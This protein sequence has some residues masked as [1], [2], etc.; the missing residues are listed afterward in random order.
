MS[1]DSEDEIGAQEPVLGEKHEYA[2]PR[3][4]PEDANIIPPMIKEH[5]AC[6]ASLPNEP[7]SEGDVYMVKAEQLPEK[8]EPFVPDIILDDNC[9]HCGH[10][11]QSPSEPNPQ[12]RRNARK[13][14]SSAYSSGSDDTDEDSRSSRDDSLPNGLDT[15]SLIRENQIIYAT[16]IDSYTSFKQLYCQLRTDNSRLS[17]KLSSCSDLFSSEPF[18]IFPLPMEPPSKLLQRYAA[19]IRDN[20]ELLHAAFL[21]VYD[22]VIMNPV[23]AVYEGDTQSRRACPQSDSDDDVIPGLIDLF[24]IIDTAIIMLLVKC[25]HFV[26]GLQI[27]QVSPAYSELPENLLRRYV[28]NVRINVASLATQFPVLANFLRNF[29]SKDVPAPPKPSIQPTSPLKPVN[30]SQSSA[31][32]QQTGKPPA[33]ELSHFHS[34]TVLPAAD[35]NTKEGCVVS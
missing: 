26:R 7:G 17:S 12:T 23:G 15:D 3:Q 1:S 24:M 13:R 28:A 14:I 8:L 9:P 5:L 19:T 2:P 10:L 22:K 21:G 25:S 16:V 6:D 32:P 29:E 30:G 11:R 27:K 34:S 18:R 20:L 31:N 35:T 33:P 4:E